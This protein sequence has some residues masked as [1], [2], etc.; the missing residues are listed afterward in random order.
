MELIKGHVKTKGDMRIL[1]K[2]D[3]YFPGLETEK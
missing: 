1:K 3:E 2:L